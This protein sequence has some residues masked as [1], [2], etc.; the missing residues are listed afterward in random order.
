MITFKD[1]RV[2][3]YFAD[4]FMLYY[5]DFGPES[6]LEAPH[7]AQLQRKWRRAI[8]QVWKMLYKWMLWLWLQKKI[9]I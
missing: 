8:W 4:F 7:G 5:P 2:S 1:F 9:I 3:K 6:F